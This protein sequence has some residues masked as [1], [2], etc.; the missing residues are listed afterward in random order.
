[1]EDT[2]RTGIWA[3][4]AACRSMRKED[5]RNVNIATGLLVAWVVTFGFSVVA[6]RRSLVPEGALSYLMV[7]VPTALAILA[8]LAYGRFLRLADELHSK[9]QFEAF[10]LGFGA[11]FVATFSF[12]LLQAAGVHSF[13]LADAFS[14]MVVFYMVGLYRGARRYA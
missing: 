7:A 13:S 6:L 3:Y 9:I 8:V 11:G 2:N 10:A 5:R 14:V 4:L 12:S 1:M